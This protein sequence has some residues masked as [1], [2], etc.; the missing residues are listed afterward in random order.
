MSCFRTYFD[1][2]TGKCTDEHQVSSAQQPSGNS[3]SPHPSCSRAL[4]L[5]G[6]GGDARDAAVGEAV[7]DKQAAAHGCASEGV[8]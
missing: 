4:T 7:L 2:W 3:S 5:P 1:L 8:G 6:R